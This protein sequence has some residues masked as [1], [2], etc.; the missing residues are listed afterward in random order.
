MSLMRN[1]TW[2]NV[3]QHRFRWWRWRRQRPCDDRRVD[4]DVLDRHVV[5]AEDVQLLDFDDRGSVD[6]RRYPVGD[7]RGDH[8]NDGD[9]PPLFRSV[10]AG[11]VELARVIDRSHGYA[12]PPPRSA[13]IGS[14]TP[15]EG[16]AD[17]RGASESPRAKLDTLHSPTRG[18]FQVSR[19]HSPAATGKTAAVLTG[20]RVCSLLEGCMAAH[21][22]VNA[23]KRANLTT[24]S[25]GCVCA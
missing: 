10:L 15:G 2:R 20:T 24:R 8:R 5:V 17:D 3:D 1:R 18:P 12:P 4:L 11:V 14:G 13:R 7:R 9:F 6:K 25:Q 23:L 19:P 22:Y 16:E 21:A